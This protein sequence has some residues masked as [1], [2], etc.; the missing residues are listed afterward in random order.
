MECI[1]KSTEILRKG[2]C[3]DMDQGF[4]ILA[5]RPGKWK[6]LMNFDVNCNRL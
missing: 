3:E 4:I 1:T 5:Y 6:I 2:D